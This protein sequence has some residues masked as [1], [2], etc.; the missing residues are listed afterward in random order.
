MMAYALGPQGRQA[1]RDYVTSGGGYI[2][3]CAGAFDELL[4]CVVLYMHVCSVV[5]AWVNG[6]TTQGH[7]FP[8]RSFQ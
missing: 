7:T 3:V 8:L 4:S 6:G 2:G 1:I 5:Y